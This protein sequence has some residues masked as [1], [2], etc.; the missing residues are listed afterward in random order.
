M[1]SWDRESYHSIQSE[2]FKEGL[3]EGDPIPPDLDKP[4]PHKITSRL[5]DQ[6]GLNEKGYEQLLLSLTSPLILKENRKLGLFTYVTLGAIVGDYYRKNP[7]GNSAFPYKD[8]LYTIQYQTWWNTKKKYRI[9][10]QN[11]NVYDNTNRALDWMEVS[12][13]FD[14]PNTSGAF[15]SFKDSSIPTKVYFDKSYERLKKI[16][17]DLCED[18]HNHFRSRK[19][20]I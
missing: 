11:S 13:D 6:K 15:I 10:G 12:R 7:D 19:T 4:A 20:I 16:K 18:P 2:M 9:K 14:I 3:L 5:V 8:K 17:I 1:S